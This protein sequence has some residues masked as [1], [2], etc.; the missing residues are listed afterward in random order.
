MCQTQGFNPQAKNDYQK[1]LGKRVIQHNYAFDITVKPEKIN[2][3]PTKKC[4]LCLTGL[5]F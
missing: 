1:F 2:K 4:S 5:K 3:T